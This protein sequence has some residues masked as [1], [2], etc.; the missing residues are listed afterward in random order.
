M[1]QVKGEESKLTEGEKTDV[2]DV[3]DV[4]EEGQEGDMPTEELA[5][6]RRQVSECAHVDAMHIVVGMFAKTIAWEKSIMKVLCQI[7][8]RDD[9]EEEL[10]L[11]DGC[12]LGYHTVPSL[13]FPSL[14]YSFPTPFLC[15][16]HAQFI[17][18]HCLG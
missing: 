5:S 9:N 8:K 7:C 17:S 16:T 3:G 12:D 10:L 11:C 2:A 1:V 4:A 15:I 6:W 18:C 14:S 13:P